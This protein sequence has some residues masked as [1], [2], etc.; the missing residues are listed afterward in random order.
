MPGD[1]L[2]RQVDGSAPDEL[3][4]ALNDGNS[5]GF[6]ISSTTWEP[7]GGWSG[8]CWDDAN[9][10][11]PTGCIESV[12]TVAATRTYVLEFGVVNWGDTLFDS[13][14]AFDFGG[15]DSA[16]F[17]NVTLIDNGPT[18]AVPEPSTWALWLA[19][20]GLMGMAIRR[21]VPCN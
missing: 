5:V 3:D 16:R 10:C 20:L 13:A 15:L 2:E 19:G 11:G 7:L 21:K 17:D 9:T 18:P 8:C 4:A 1:V 14:M 12:Y 6:N